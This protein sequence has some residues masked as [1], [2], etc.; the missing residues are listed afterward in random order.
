MNEY[1]RLTVKQLQALL[2]EREL[3][4]ERWMLYFLKKHEM[5]RILEANRSV[6]QADKDSLRRRQKRHSE[7]T[8]TAKKDRTEQFGTTKTTAEERLTAAIDRRGPLTFSGMKE[9]DEPFESAA[10]SKRGKVAVVFIDAAGE[11]FL[12]TKGEAQQAKDRGV[13]VPFHVFTASRKV[14]MPRTNTHKTMKDYWN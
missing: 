8:M 2:W 1:D 13:A 7:K 10:G 6:S 5:C 11:E 9:F 4:P 14:K 3:I 12:L